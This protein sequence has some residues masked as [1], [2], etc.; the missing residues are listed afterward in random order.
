MVVLGL[1]LILV[2]VIAVPL[3]FFTGGT[4]TLELLHL[5]RTVFQILVAGVASGA[6]VL[7]GITLSRLG[8]TLLGD[9]ARDHGPGPARARAVRSWD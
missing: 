6:F 8:L 4:G 5:D 7:W 3:A 2:G 9:P 1:L